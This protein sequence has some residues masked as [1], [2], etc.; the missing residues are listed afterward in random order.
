MPN[1]SIGR[2]VSVNGLAF[3][4]SNVAVAESSTYIN[5]VTLAA[6][7][8]GVQAS[9][10][11]ASAATFTMEASHGITTASVVDVY[12]TLSGS[13]YVR[14]GCTVGT[15]SGT[16]V[17]I[18]SGGAGDSFTS[19]V[20]GAYTMF[21]ALEEPFVIPASTA[22][23]ILVYLPSGKGVVRFRD[24]TDAII[25]TVAKSAGTAALYEWNYQT[26]GTIP[27][28]TDEIATILWSNG[29]TTTQAPTVACTFTA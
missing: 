4:D 27:F 17:P 12:W 2:S 21:L 25:L 7:K 14:Y 13:T 23:S 3:T 22:K 20:G 1:Y 6:A 24:D 8:T 10:S 16:S 11:S 29:N 9:Y 26:G 19:N 5:G 28:S 18:A 15:V